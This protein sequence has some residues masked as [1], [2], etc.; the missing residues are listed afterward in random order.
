[1]LLPYV[2]FWAPDDGRK[3]R[4]K[5]VE[6]FTGTD[7]LLP[8]AAG[9]SSCLTYA[10]AVCELLSSWWW[11]EGP[12]ETCRTFYRNGYFEKDVHFVGCAIRIYYDARTLKRQIQ[13]GSL[14]PRY[15]LIYFRIP[16]AP[17]SLEQI[18]WN[19]HCKNLSYEPITRIVLHFNET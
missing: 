10:L 17:L 11:T 9:S 12:S 18:A 6:R 7:N 16:D 4:P 5:H 8:L 19:T 15:I 14:D 13:K 1:M 3:D 2:N